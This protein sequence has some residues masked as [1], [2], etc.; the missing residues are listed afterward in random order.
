MIRA[1]C[2]AASLLL[3]ACD[4]GGG[5]APNAPPPD[6]Q[7]A[8]FDAGTPVDARVDAGSFQDAGFDA[9]PP[10]PVDAG[11]SCQCDL[12]YGCSTCPAA[13]I[14]NFRNGKCT[15]PGYTINSDGSVNDNVTG[16][17]WQEQI[18]SNP[19]P[20]DGS[21]LCTWQ[22]AQNYCQNLSHGG[23]P[24]WRVPTLSELYSL[25]DPGGSPAIDSAG[26][27][28]TPPGATCWT[29]SEYGGNPGQ[30]WYVNFK[31]GYASANIVT[32]SL[33]VRCVH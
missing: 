28:N 5:M 17:V 3:F 21:G 20:A 23:S 8:G 19:C 24:T 12:T 30:D 18:P 33:N 7:D 14:C 32:D 2:L 25:V 27:P 1:L 6:D 22:D 26:F 9:G 10:A 31:A 4:S 11:I 15:T 29:A 16:L 13:T